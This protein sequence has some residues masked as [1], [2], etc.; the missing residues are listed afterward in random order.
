MNVQSM[1]RSSH[2]ETHHSP[3]HWDVLLPLDFKQFPITQV[4]A[5]C[6]ETSEAFIY[7]ILER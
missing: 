6:L 3:V 7:E 4:A 1:I 2:G 5:G